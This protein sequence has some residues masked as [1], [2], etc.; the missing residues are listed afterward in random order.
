M[1]KGF[2]IFFICIKVYGQTDILDLDRMIKYGEVETL[3]ISFRNTVFSEQFLK[4]FN[5][6]EREIE[7]VG[8]W[9]SIYTVKQEQTGVGV[10][11]LGIDIY[12]N[13]I[14]EISLGWRKERNVMKT[15][16]FALWRINNNELQICPTAI[17]NEVNDITKAG[18][19][20]FLFLDCM[21]YFTIGVITE[22]YK[23]FV[24]INPWDFSMINKV[25]GSIPFQLGKDT[26]R[27][28]M[29]SDP[30]IPIIYE[31]IATNEKL[32]HF[33]LHPVLNDEKYFLEL[34]RSK[35]WVYQLQYEYKK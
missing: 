28:R 15:F 33:L 32:R 26:L 8:Y 6:S 10:E 24:L 18:L 21:E 3:E 11:I 13:R 17:F 22:F 25:L 20:N 14:M 1:R 34:L 35:S 29:I 23:A 5:L 12:P 4:I 30:A 19:E 31:R 7:L 16:L 27:S 9:T 2:I